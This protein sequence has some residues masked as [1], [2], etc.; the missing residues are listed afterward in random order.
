[1]RK[2]EVIKFIKNLPIPDPCNGCQDEGKDCCW[3][4]YD[5]LNSEEAVEEFRQTI[6]KGLEEYHHDFK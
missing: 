3:D 6:L 5:W 1:M 4:C 2:R